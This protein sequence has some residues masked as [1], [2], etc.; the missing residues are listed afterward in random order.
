FLFSH[1]RT[2]Y[3][4]LR[5]LADAQEP[6]PEFRLEGVTL[7]FNVDADYEVVRTQLAHNIVAVVPGSDPKLSDT[8]VAFGAHY[9]HVGY[10]EGEVAETPDGPRGAAPRGRVTP[11]AINDRIWNGADDDGSGTVALLALAHAFAE[12]PRPRRSLLFDW[13][14]GEEAG[15]LGSRFFADYPS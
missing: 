13:H 1:A 7:T 3:A 12:G 6:L 14:T 4:E 10:S 15:L 11:A 5:R 8:F 2:P 9:D